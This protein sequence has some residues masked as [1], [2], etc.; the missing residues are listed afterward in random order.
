MTHQAKT[1]RHLP[2]EVEAIQYDGTSESRCAIAVFAGHWVSIGYAYGAVKVSVTT[3]RG[4]V[5]LMS[6]DWLV[7][8]GKSDFYPCPAALFEANYD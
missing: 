7:K 2:T 4:S 6:G 3:P 5:E 1:F 8:G